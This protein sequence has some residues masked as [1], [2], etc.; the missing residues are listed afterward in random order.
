[1]ILINYHLFPYYSDS[2][3]KEFPTITISKDKDFKDLKNENRNFNKINLDEKY[4]NNQLNEI[5]QNI[6]G[7]LIKDMGGLGSMKTLS[8]RGLSANQ[9]TIM[10]DGIPINN[11]SNG[12]VD[13]SIISLPLFEKV[14][15]LKSGNNENSL[16]GGINLV[17]S[18]IF[19]NKL[20][21][22][23][24]IGSFGDYEIALKLIDTSIGSQ[25]ACS[26]TRYSG[27]FNYSNIINGEIKE[28]IRENSDFSNIS[29]LFKTN[30]NPNNNLTLIYKNISR[31]IPEPV[32]QD[33][34]STSKSSTNENDL[35]LIYNSGFGNFNFSSSLKFN[36][37][38]YKNDNGFSNLT[39]TKIIDYFSKTFISS[40]DYQFDFIEINNSISLSYNFSDLNGD[41]LEPKINRYVY[42]SNLN[43]NYGLN[44]QIFESKDLI[45]S[46]FNSNNLIYKNE[47]INN[48]DNLLFNSSISNKYK[49]KNYDFSINGIISFNNRVPSFNEMY[50]LNYGNTK[51]KTES[52][53]NYELMLSKEFS[54]Y[55]EIRS[56]LFYYNIKNQILSVPSS[57][58]S[59]SAMNIGKVDNIGFELSAKSS[60]FNNKLN[61]EIE[62]C[63]QFPKNSDKNSMNYGKIIPYISQEMLSLNINYKIS[64]FII[65][66]STLYNSFRFSL[67]D[68]SFNSIIPEFSICN[69]IIDYNLKIN[70]NNNFLL[71]LK[72]DNLLDKRYEIIKNYP[73]PGRIF[74]IGINYEKFN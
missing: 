24:S 40:L 51:L 25:I 21:S 10:I 59:W 20:N 48:D 41:M 64:D 37:L 52:A 54:K 63:L 6:S 47:N 71:Y 29:L 1:M 74:K 39:N 27:D 72:I 28:L 11:S 55:L 31:K 14:E 26:Y 17:S 13:I 33:Y 60:I 18:D 19:R 56:S 34:L 3:F 32:L 58:I 70:G 8:L 22:S 30:F 62:Y 2:V 23:I 43:F 68:N 4:S 44:Y 12:M 36:N 69:A 57:P 61:T 15:V 50:Y 65:Y 35:L 9:T 53:I 73:L 66:L 5:M 49:L 45:I 38:N 67:P 42:R 7:I 16:I 46:I